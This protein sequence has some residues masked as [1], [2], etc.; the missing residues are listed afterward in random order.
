MLFTKLDQK[1]RM[2]GIFK[3]HFCGAEQKIALKSPAVLLLKM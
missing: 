2:P 3:G 1:I